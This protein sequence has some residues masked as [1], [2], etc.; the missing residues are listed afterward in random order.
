M[1]HDKHDRITIVDEGV[2]REEMRS[3]SRRNSSLSIGSAPGR[4]VAPENLLPITYRTLSFK[5]D[6]TSGKDAKDSNKQEQEQ[7]K[8]LAELDYHLLS[9]DELHKRFTTSPQGLQNEQLNR[10]VA[11]YGKNQ[12]SPPPSRWFR[13]LMGYMFGGFGSILLG[14]GILVFIAWKPL[15]HPPAQANLALAIVLV[16]VWVLQA[17]FNGWQDWS[18]SQVMASI[19]TMLPGQ[20]V[21]VRNGNP[22]D[23]S[24]VDLVPGDLIQIKQG[25]K[26]PADV[27]L[28]Q[29]SADVKFDRSILTG[30]SEPVPGSVDSTNKN[31]LE[32]NN[33]GLQGTYCV[34]GAALGIVVGT[35]DQT[36]FGRIA[37]LSHGRRTELTP[38]QKEILRFVL[39]IASFIITFVVIIIIIWAGYLRRD[40]PDFIDVPT[41][42]VSCVSVGI[43]F[44]PE[45]LPIA[46]SM[47]L[48]IAAGIM[49][50]NKILCKSLATVET[51]GAVSVICSDKTGT[52]T[53]NE[54]FVTDCFS[55]NEEYTS[56]EAKERMAQGIPNKSISLV[57][58]VGGLCNAAEFDASTL[59]RPLHAV[60]VFGDPTD[61]AILRLSQS[62]G[63]VNNLRSR[64]KKTFEI[65]FNS[66]N[67]FM[68]RVMKSVDQDSAYLFIKGA[69]DMLLSKCAYAINRNGEAEVLSQSDRSKIEAVKDHWSAKGKRVILMAQ[70]LLSSDAANAACDEKAVL[71][72][73]VDGLTLVGLVGLIDPPRDEIPSVVNTLRGASI[74]I[75]MVTGDYKLTAQAI[76]IA[77]GIIRTHPDLVDDIKSLDHY[78]ETAIKQ[79]GATTAIVISGPELA[80]L[81]DNDWDRICGYD[82]IVFARTTPEQKLRIV[83]EFQARDNIVAMT[84]DGVNDA[85]SLKAADV[86]VALGSGSDVAIEA[87]DIV[88]LDSFSAIVEAV[89]YGRLVYDNLKKTVIYLLPAGSFSELWPVITNVVLGVPQIL[90]SFLMIIICCLTDCAGAITLAFEKPESDL[91]LRPPRN[92][93]KDRLVDAKLLG[94]AYFFIGLYECFMSYAMAFWYMQRKGIPFSAMVLRYGSMDPQYDPDYVTQVANEASSIYFVNLVF[95]QFFNLLAVRTRR[96]SIFQQPPILK[97]ETQN[98]LLF[99]AMGFA[100]CVVFIFLYIPALHDS[101]DTTTVPVEHFFLPIAFGLGL[102]FLD[103]VRKYSV[104]RWP[105]GVL[106]KIAW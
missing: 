27:R 38:M 51:L 39:I 20:C 16:A 78:D 50:K 11:K 70:K 86:G 74:R 44:I 52:L 30:E 93:K 10:L 72:S 3:L 24:A 87:A 7:I 12:P 94:H 43:A 1:E 71:E 54:M 21:A 61:Q 65:P 35:G 103:E 69:P 88:L 105:K 73:A 90:S 46:I 17:A 28:I 106:A 48:T 80:D 22:T 45:G 76:A 56:D 66:K 99:P 85:P 92:P 33:I 40:H 4:V 62:L 81:S 26:L 14:G 79:P 96:L 23:L 91:L 83:K 82:E 53:K 31:F 15:G 55:G 2:P 18:S 6:D 42:I 60:K 77:C 29:A 47:G 102:L 89:K 32:T 9:V 13:T 97:R 58:S 36:V 68:V 25:N 37:S 95:M 59:D 49:K 19:T 67:K 64:W 98:L 84:G 101:I 41:L 100:L 63:P 5:V 57:R 75:M 8:G 34:S 104:R